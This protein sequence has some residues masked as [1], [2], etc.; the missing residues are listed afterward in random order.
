[1]VMTTGGYGVVTAVPPVPQGPD[2]TSQPIRFEKKWFQGLS[3]MRLVISLFSL[4]II[5]FFLYFIMAM[6]ADPP[7]EVYLLFLLITSPFILYIMVL[8]LRTRP[9][10]FEMDQR[11]V[12]LYRGEK[13]VKEVLFGPHVQVGVVLVGYWDDFSPGLTFRAIGMDE[14]DM[15]MFNR[16]GY[17]PLFGYR[18]RG[19]GKK[20]VISRKKGWDIRWIQWM[21]T[22]LNFEMNRYGMQPDGSM[23]RYL[24]KRRRMGLPIP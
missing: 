3:W 14:N 4:F 5:F 7:P 8:I 12:R 18:F 13:V 23:H 19:G 16:Q 20:I 24:E 21:W 15:S 6:G 11:G 1:M 2:I 17:G 22:P 9:A 10:G